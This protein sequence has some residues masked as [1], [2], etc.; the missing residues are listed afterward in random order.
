MTKEAFQSKVNR[1]TRLMGVEPKA[2][3]SD[4]RTALEQ[5]PCVETSDPE[6]LCAA[7]RVSVRI[8][9]YNHERWIAEA[10]E[11]VLMQECDFTFEIVI[12]ED[13]STD[14]TRGICLDYQKRF[15]HIIR[16]LH[17]D[18][19]VGIERNSLR[20]NA[21]LRGEYVCAFE[22]DDYWLDTRK[23]QKQ[24]DLM[25]KHPDASLCVAFTK[26]A[27]GDG[28]AQIEQ[29]PPRVKERLA[30]RDLHAYFYHPSARMMTRAYL[31]QFYAL[32]TLTFSDTSI[33]L[34]ASR[35]GGVVQLPEHLAVYRCTGTGAFSG[36]GQ[37]ARLRI[38]MRIAS[39]TVV[40]FY[41]Q[42]RSFF[43]QKIFQMA[44]DFL[45]A[46]GNGLSRAE[47]REVFRLAC[48][49]VGGMPTR[50]VGKA[51]RF[52]F[53]YLLPAREGGRG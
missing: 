2:M 4:I 33:L 38:A 10:I 53:E 32:D 37:L 52:L 46:D 17:S 20:T 19:N 44:M 15:P 27:H 43:T 23:L 22:G 48:T 39:E 14:K 50:R 51:L 30:F 12:G 8:L 40:F 7:P 45:G 49:L 21:R 18:T 35:F 16:V 36:A 31:H 6:K 3:S 1:L 29:K 11:S 42:H 28:A 9:T 34:A 13:C 26:T 5:I 47:R 41:P 24:V 25:R